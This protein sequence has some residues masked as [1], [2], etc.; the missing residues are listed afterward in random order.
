MSC[1]EWVQLH[2]GP[3][4]SLASLA[5]ANVLPWS[6]LE[7]EARSIVE[8]FVATWEKPLQDRGSTEHDY[9]K[10]ISAHPAFFFLQGHQVVSKPELGSEYRPDFVV[11]CDQR[12]QGIHYRFIEIESPHAVACTAQGNPSTRL[13]RALQQVMDWKGWVKGNP[14]QYK[15]LF[16]SN[17]LCVQEFDNLVLLCLHRTAQSKLQIDRA[18]QRVCQGGGR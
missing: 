14:G 2:S 17:Y 10:F 12:S 18:S 7:A 1:L 8:R 9:H 15:K 13:T 4:P 6:L 5:E 16:P 11:A 3:R